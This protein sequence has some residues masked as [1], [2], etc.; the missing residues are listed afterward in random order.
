[1]AAV[2]MGWPWTAACIWSPEV[3]LDL[4]HSRLGFLLQ[5]EGE[6]LMNPEGIPGGW[7]LAV[8]LLGVLPCSW[9]LSL[10]LAPGAA[11]KL[12][13]IALLKTCKRFANSLLSYSSQPLTTAPWTSV[14]SSQLPK[15]LWCLFFF[16]WLF[17][18][19]KLKIVDPSVKKNKMM[20][21]LLLDAGKI[22]SA[23]IACVEWVLIFT[24]SILEW[25]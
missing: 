22:S 20:M 15:S 8:C 10:G 6:G 25:F 11:E 7:N 12:P 16:N 2:C 18:I 1:M 24:H 5:E 13:A 19:T 17:T 4:F 9:S 23:Y 14:D 3:L 21:Y